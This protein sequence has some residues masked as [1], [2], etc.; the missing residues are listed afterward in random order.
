[1]HLIHPQNPKK[2][3]LRFILGMTRSK[4]LTEMNALEP[5]I[6]AICPRYNKQ[7]QILTPKVFW[8]AIE[9]LGPNP[10]VVNERIIDYNN[11]IN[12]NIRLND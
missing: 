9:E 8:L 5:D 6:M 10:E 2:S 3:L 7:C 12:R 4:F 11:K 1:M